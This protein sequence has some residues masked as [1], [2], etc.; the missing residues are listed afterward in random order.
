MS[1]KSLAADMERIKYLKEVAIP[2]FEK[3]IKEF[4][5]EAAQLPVDDKRRVLYEKMISKVLEAELNNA[6][7]EVAKV[8]RAQ[9]QQD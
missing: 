9:C 2:T 8:E 6:Q 7:E 4:G 3:L 5:E 1:E